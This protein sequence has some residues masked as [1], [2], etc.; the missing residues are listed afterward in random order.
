MCDLSV[1]AGI[2]KNASRMGETETPIPDKYQE[3][4][5]RNF[6]NCWSPSGMQHPRWLSATV[7]H[8]CNRVNNQWIRPVRPKEFDRILH[9]K[10]KKRESVLTHDHA[11]DISSKTTLPAYASHS[12]WRNNGL[13]THALYHDSAC[14]PWFVSYYEHNLQYNC[15]QN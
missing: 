11:N 2:R 15:S 8:L 5:V 13:N 14:I 9:S 10:Q 1:R 12:P 6:H 3:R 7:S 4:R